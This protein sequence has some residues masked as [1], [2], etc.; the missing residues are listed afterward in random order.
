MKRPA[1]SVWRDERGHATAEAVIMLPFFILVWG[2]IIFMSQG[3]ERAIDVGAK[4]REHAWAHAMDHCEGGVGA[5]TEV[6]DATEPAL[7]PFGDL[8]DMIDE[9]IAVLPLVG[10]IW[11]GFINEERKFGRRSS[12]EKPTVLGAGSQRIAH[13]IVLMCNEEPQDTTLAEL[14]DHAWGIFGL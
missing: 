9:I 14:A 11:P 2:C 8:F 10:E 6:Y 3:Y 7:G 13:T 5:G 4:T 12:V 1:R